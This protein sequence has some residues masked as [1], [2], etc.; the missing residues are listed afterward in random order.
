MKQ[1]PIDSAE[2]LKGLFVRGLDGDDEAIEAF[3]SG[4]SSHLRAYL[5]KR[6]V[7][8]PDEVEDLVQ[9]SLIAIHGKRWTFDRDKPIGAWAFAIAK[10]KLVDFLRAR[11]AK[12]AVTDSLDETKER[13][14]FIASAGEEITAKQDI[15]QLLDLLPDKQRLP[16]IHTKI[17]GLSVAEAARITGLSVSAVKV[18]VHRGLRALAVLVKNR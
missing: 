13:E 5:A 12:D 10:Y 15:A 11:G 14:L 8:Y 18:G 17:E 9:E 16:I 7:S 2:R 3:Y 6:L 4:L 1:A